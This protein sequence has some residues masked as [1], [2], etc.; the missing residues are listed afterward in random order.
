MPNNAF[1]TMMASGSRQNEDNL[2]EMYKSSDGVSDVEGEKLLHN[3]IVE[4]LRQH[5]I[6]CQSKPSGADLVKKMKDT[7]KLLD[8]SVEII[9]KRNGAI[10]EVLGSLG[11]GFAKGERKGSWERRHV[12]DTAVKTKKVSMYLLMSI[13]VTPPRMC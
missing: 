10:K 3:D 8:S 7:V 2:P 6:G 4:S 5:K 1:A 11:L 9:A 13:K 12:Y